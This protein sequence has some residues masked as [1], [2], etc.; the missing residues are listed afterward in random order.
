MVHENEL[1]LEELQLGSHA[2][3]GHGLGTMSLGLRNRDK[4]EGS[5]CMVW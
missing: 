4:I 1:T 3:E 5:S 2:Q